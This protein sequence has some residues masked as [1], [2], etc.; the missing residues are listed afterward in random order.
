MDLGAGMAGQPQSAI[1][2][3]PVELA[4]DILSFCHP[5]DVAA[6]SKTCRGAYALVYQ[7][8][9]Q[10]LWRQL[11]HGYS[12][13]PP[14][15]SS[16]PSR[17]KE[18]KDWKKELICRM[19][20]ELI[21]FRGPRTEVETKEMLQT[22]ITVIED[23]SYILSR[24]GFSRN[25]KWLKRM[26]RQSLLLNNLYSISTEDDAEAQLHAQIRSYLA[27]TIHPKQDES[28]LALFLERRDT[29]RAYVYNLEHYKATN[30]W[31]PFHT[32]GSVNW[33]HVEYL[34]DV[35]SCNIR[36]LPGSWAQTRP[37]S[38]LDPPREGRASGLMSEEDWAGVEGTWRRYVCFMDY[39]DLFA[40]NFT[41]LAG[42]P[43]NPKFFKDPR[44]REA[45]RL[46][47][48]KLHIARSSELRYYR[49]P[50]ESHHPA[51]P[52]LCIGGSSKGVNGNEAIVEG[53]VIM[54]Q[55]GVARW[56]IISI[57]DDHPQWSSHG[58][59]IGG[60]GSAM[61]VIGVWTTTNHDPDDPAGPFWLWKVED[62][63]P[64]HLMEFT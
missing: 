6:F 23:S 45:T 30:Q 52:T 28:T 46:I 10:Y 13:D 34:Q 60:V 58:V 19:K 21:L 25:T 15:Y 37:P 54:G 38:C 12:F 8:T 42:G 26:V 48:L 35:V 18:K 27:L 51:Y 57:Y 16:E 7:S 17:R 2:T 61:G 33:T 3:F 53:C 14:Q 47:E 55:D 32:D 4:Q 63:S 41:E 31:G 49:P 24:T 22:L 59:Q 11:F 29:S 64:T 62:N 40:F 50:T 20:A 44:F 39:R 1:F 9:D 43:K 36:E 56:E 5:W